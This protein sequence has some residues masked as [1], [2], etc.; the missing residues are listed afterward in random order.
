[1]PRAREMQSHRME[2]ERSEQIVRVE[3]TLTEFR[4]YQA[5]L[6]KQRLAEVESVLAMIEA[7]GKLENKVP[8]VLASD[9]Q[10]RKAK[11]AKEEAEELAEQ[12]RW[13]SL[14]V[15]EQIAEILK[16]VEADKVT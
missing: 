12:R 7:D 14:S 6:K 4:E 1:M 2:E 5:W 8:S 3:M 13:D 15:Q 10:E 16:M 9:W 11:E